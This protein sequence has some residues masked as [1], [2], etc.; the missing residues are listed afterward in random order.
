MAGFD[1][2]GRCEGTKHDYY[3]GGP[4]DQEFWLRIE[5]NTTGDTLKI[6]S[7]FANQPIVRVVSCDTKK[8]KQEGRAG[9]PRPWSG[10][11]S[12]E[13]GGPP[14]EW[15]DGGGTLG[16]EVTNPYEQCDLEFAGF[17]KLRVSDKN[18]NRRSLKK[19]V[20]TPLKNSGLWA[21]DAV[22][23]DRFKRVDDGYVAVI[24]IQTTYCA[25]KVQDSVTLKYD[26]TSLSERSLVLI[27]ND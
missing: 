15:V 22:Q 26:K 5:E 6:L 21:E 14:D 4:S 16:S 25:Q 10:N 1:T 8:K 13:S 12:G 18:G 24:S 3:T 9:L 20:L 17:I 11:E 23:L 7:K 2:E 19:E 27:D